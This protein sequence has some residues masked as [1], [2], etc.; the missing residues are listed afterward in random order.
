MDI[1]A[2]WNVAAQSNLPAIVRS[3]QR[4]DAKGFADYLGR[5][6]RPSRILTMSGMPMNIV[7][8]DKSRLDK[9]GIHVLRG[10]YFR[11]TGKRLTAEF[12]VRVASKAGLAADHP[13]METIARVFNL[14][15]DHRN[16]A[17]GR[18]FSYVAGFGF[19]RSVWLM[20]LYDYYFWMATIDER[21]ESER[22]M[23]DAPGQASNP[24][25]M[26]TESR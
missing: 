19:G 9:T 18:A 23:D 16:G 2:N 8:T 24:D 5:Q 17:V 15:R 13:D 26:A 25:N 20:L 7:S 6:S 3:L 21:P 12:D 11:E 14:L 4:K 10:L 1:R 22:E